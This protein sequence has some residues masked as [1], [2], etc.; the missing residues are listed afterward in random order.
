MNKKEW[1]KLSGKDEKVL[2]AILDIYDKKMQERDSSELG[3]PIWISTR[4][5]SEACDIN[6]YRARY[7]L[8]KLKSNG[9]IIQ[10]S[11]RRKTHGWRPSGILKC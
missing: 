3:E 5:I 11:V 6:I 10:D 7:S 2:N 8:L 1:Y 9:G 4:E